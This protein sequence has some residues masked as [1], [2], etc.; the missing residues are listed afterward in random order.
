MDELNLEFSNEDALTEFVSHTYKMLEQDSKIKLS[1]KMDLFNTLKSLLQN[2]RD[3]IYR[4]KAERIFK[5]KEGV[6]ESLEEH[7]GEIEQIAKKL[8]REDFTRYCKKTKEL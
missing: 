5:G 3:F 7:I 4:I 2:F 1:R 6:K 8:I